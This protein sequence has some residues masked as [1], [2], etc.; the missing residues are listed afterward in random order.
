MSSD[1][2]PTP[3]IKKKDLQKVAK[4]MQHKAEE[5]ERKDYPVSF[6]YC[7]KKSFSLFFIFFFFS[8]RIIAKDL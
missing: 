7:L 1:T 2:L 6:F 5:L 8:F 4:I 3:T